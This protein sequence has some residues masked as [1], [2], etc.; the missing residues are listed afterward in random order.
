MTRDAIDSWANR[1]TTR[2]SGADIRGIAQILIEAST[3]A[4]LLADNSKD[5]FEADHR[6]KPDS[7]NE[8]RELLDIALTDMHA[9]R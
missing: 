7:L 6:P 4:E 9:S 3:R 1:A 2:F 5:V 8:L